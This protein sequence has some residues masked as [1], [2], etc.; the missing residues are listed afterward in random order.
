MV[1]CRNDR[2]DTCL[3]VY[4]THCLINN[5]PLLLLVLFCLGTLNV[6]EREQLKHQAVVLAVGYKL[7]LLNSRKVCAAS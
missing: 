1:L 3:T 2:Q 4:C 6:Q 7:F 5:V